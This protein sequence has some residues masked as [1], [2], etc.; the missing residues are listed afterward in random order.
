MNTPS[1]AEGNWRFRLTDWML[2]EALR[3]RFAD[4]AWLYGR[5]V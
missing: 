5:A 3:D 4:L 1:K 2:S